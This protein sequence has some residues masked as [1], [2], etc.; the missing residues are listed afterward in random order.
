MRGQPKK[1]GPV[2]KEWQVGRDNDSTSRRPRT[3]APGLA[4]GGWCRRAEP[5]ARTGGLRAALARGRAADPGGPA[6]YYSHLGLRPPS[7]DFDYNQPLIREGPND[8]ILLRNAQKKLVRSLHRLTKLGKGFFRDKYYEYLV[9]VPVIIRGRWR[10]RNAGAGYERS[11][12]RAGRGHEAPGAPH[13]GAGAQRVRQ[14]AE[15]S[16]DPGGPILQLLDE[17]HFLD[18]EG[19]WRNFRT[20][21]ETLLRQRMRGLR[22]VSCLRGGVLPSAFEDKPL[23]V[24]S[25]GGHSMTPEATRLSKPRLPCCGSRRAAPAKSARCGRDA[26]PGRLP[27]GPHPACWA[28]PRGATWTR[29]R[30]GAW[31]PRGPKASSA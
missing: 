24:P 12:E 31:T 1:T 9:H 15:A 14:Q 7:K 19:H 2:K 23:C 8:Y 22:S 30:A 26:G 16:L 28:S 17:T 29:R 6:L 20:E 18:P 10:R 3:A 13:G 5:A 4:R 27:L 25:C 11:G 21:V